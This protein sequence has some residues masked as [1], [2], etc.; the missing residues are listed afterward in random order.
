[1]GTEKRETDE[2][3]EIEKIDNENQD[4]VAKNNIK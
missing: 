4:V 3:F 1:M 2:D